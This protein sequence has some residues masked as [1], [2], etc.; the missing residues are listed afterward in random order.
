[1]VV[2]WNMVIGWN[3]VFGWIAR[4]NKAGYLSGDW[5]MF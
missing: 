3:T 5:F 4:F 2:G 1:M